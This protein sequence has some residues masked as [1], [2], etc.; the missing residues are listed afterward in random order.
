RRG[1]RLIVRDGCN[2]MIPLHHSPIIAL[3]QAQ[4]APP[5]PYNT[6]QGQHS[7]NHDRVPA[8]IVPFSC[9]THDM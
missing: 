1:D 3:R 5:R 7:I 4:G 8:E 6:I 2:R 9:Q